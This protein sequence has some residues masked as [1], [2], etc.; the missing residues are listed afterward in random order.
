MATA[1]RS[2]A[3]QAVLMKISVRRSIKTIVR[4]G[5]QEQQRPRIPE[6]LLK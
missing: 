6:P 5:P 4:F 2:R 1:K 3:R